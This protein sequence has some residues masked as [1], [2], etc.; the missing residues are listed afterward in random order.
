MTSNKPTVIIGRAEHIRF[1]DFSDQLIPAKIDTG[2]DLSSVWATAIS[3]ELGTLS[4]S[5]FGPGSPYFTGKTIQLGEDDYRLTWISN[6]FGA[7]ERRYVVKLKV[8]LEGRL[9]K[10][11]FSLSNRNRKT[12]PIL[13]GR[14]LLNGK[15]IVDVSKGKILAKMSETE[16][17]KLILDIKPDQD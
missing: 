7:R 13:I 12:Y 15:F 17:A 1:V 11:S 9:I 2:A 5:L 10:A 8:R 3:E 6:S 16:R 4:F 14:K